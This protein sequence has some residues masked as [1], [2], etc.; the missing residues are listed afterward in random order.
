MNTSIKFPKK[1]ILKLID[2][3]RNT[4]FFN[5]IICKPEILTKFRQNRNKTFF[6][7]VFEKFYEYL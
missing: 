2:K 3:Y 4:I 6:N 1:I 5:K 7:N